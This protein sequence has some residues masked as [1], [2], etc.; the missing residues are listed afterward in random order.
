MVKI[1]KH[2]SKEVENVCSS[3]YP[4]SDEEDTK[5]SENVQTEDA[6]ET[7]TTP[8]VKEG[9]FPTPE[10]AKKKMKRVMTEKYA[11]KFTGGF[12]GSRMVVCV[13]C[14]RFCPKVSSNQKRVDRACAC[15]T[16][17]FTAVAHI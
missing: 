2:G 1:G 10:Q 5:T 7:P 12:L 16:C 15:V 6:K 3:P 13:G 9:E 17:K 8:P 14:S 4:S 11:Q